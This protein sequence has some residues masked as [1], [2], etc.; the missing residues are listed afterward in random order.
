[1]QQMDTKEHLVFWFSKVMYALFYIVIPIIAVGF[2]PWLI[3]FLTMGVLMGIVLATV[4]QLA[5]A[6][7]HRAGRHAQ[8]LGRQRH[9]PQPRQCL[10]GEE[11]LDGRDARG[12]GS[13]RR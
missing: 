13:W 2:L 12:H 7:A 11:A 8:L 4:F 6:V 5:H 3:G 1:M 9:R 10:E